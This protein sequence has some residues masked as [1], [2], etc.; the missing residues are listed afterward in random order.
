MR[1]TFFLMRHGQS[2]HQVQKKRLIYPWPELS[3]IF[4]TKK[5]KKDVKKTAKELKK[6]GIDIIYSSDVA[7]AQQ[8]AEIVAKELGIKVIL[9]PRLRDINFGIFQGRLEEELIKSIPLEDRISRRPPGGESW[10]DV[11]KRMLSFFREIDKK[12]KNKKILIVGHKG[13]L[14]LLEV[15]IKGLKRR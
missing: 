5:G 15:A 13:P 11:Q 7:R 12:Y 9:D 2:T 1:N 6:I 8:T 4:L 3:P 14:W 10:S